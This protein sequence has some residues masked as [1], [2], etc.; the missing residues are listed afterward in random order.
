MRVY[1]SGMHVVM[2][3]SLMELVEQP[4]RAPNN[5]RDHISSYYSDLRTSIFGSSRHMLANHT[6]LET[7]AAS[8]WDY[9]E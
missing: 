6:S 5:H 8:S 7:L 9:Y 3:N 4:E 2:R 1:G